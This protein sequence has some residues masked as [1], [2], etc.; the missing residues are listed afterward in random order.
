VS[1]GKGPPA[2]SAGKEPSSPEAV[3]KA[4]DLSMLENVP[5]A[6]G[7][8]LS[9]IRPG[10]DK[11]V[12]AGKELAAPETIRVTSE[13]F[14]DGEAIP[15]RF[16]DDGAK[17][18]PPLAFTNTPAEAKSLVLIIEDADSPTPAPLCHALV[19]GI[20]PGDGGFHEAA[21]DADAMPPARCG[22]TLGKNSFLSLGWLPPDP[23]TGHGKHRYA[24]Q[25]FALD[26]ILDL[27]EGTGR[28][29]L[30]SALHGH[31]LAKGLLIGTY[32][33]FG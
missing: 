8:A 7:H 4:E 33:R 28:G 30:V 13:A 26:V 15:A 19:W 14:A 12:Y 20:A 32:E 25:V 29:A 6:L 31:V 24:F 18:S 22:T 9:S 5:A 2:S 11:L 16:T 1:F 17:I 21:L 3:A 27:E 23:P 10:L